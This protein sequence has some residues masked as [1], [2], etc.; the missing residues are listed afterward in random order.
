MRHEIISPTYTLFKNE[1][2]NGESLGIPKSY[3]GLFIG[4][5]LP[6]YAMYYKTRAYG[7]LFWTDAHSV[8]YSDK[9]INMVSNCCENYEKYP[10]INYWGEI[11]LRSAVTNE[12]SQNCAFARFFMKCL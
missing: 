4:M 10:V 9:E 7:Q 11:I 2:K 5:F 1:K 8:I 6:I 3:D 12:N